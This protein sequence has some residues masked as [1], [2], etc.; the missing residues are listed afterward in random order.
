MFGVKKPLTQIRN[1]TLAILY[2]LLKWS[3][4]APWHFPVYQILA[5]TGKKKMFATFQ[6]PFISVLSMFLS[7]YIP[8]WQDQ[9]DYFIF[10]CF[11]D[12]SLS[13]RRQW[14]IHIGKGQLCQ[15]HLVISSNSRKQHWPVSLQQHIPS[16]PLPF[17]FPLYS[18]LRPNMPLFAYL[19]GENER[20]KEQEGRNIFLMQYPAQ[21]Y[22][23]LR[24]LWANIS[25]TFSKHF[26]S[27][28]SEKPCTLCYL[29][30]FISWTKH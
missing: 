8:V 17:C 24:M 29:W 13:N 25:N 19:L 2:V 20:G 14:N 27:S 26:P 18:V 22:V 7:I 1:A 21:G 9:E 6:M 30:H 23:I 28:P 4:T 16:H 11:S 10:F 3:Q 12:L 5:A 15:C